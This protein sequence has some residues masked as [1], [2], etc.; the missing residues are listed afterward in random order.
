MPNPPNDPRAIAPI[1]LLE[2]VGLRDATELHAELLRAFAGGGAV[3]VDASQAAALHLS[4]VQVLLA[5]ARHAADRGAGFSL[6]APEGSA[7]HGA[8]A[9]AGLALPAAVPAA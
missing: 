1:V 3:V 5:A 9:R 8:F 6:I 2:Q 4:A 7:C